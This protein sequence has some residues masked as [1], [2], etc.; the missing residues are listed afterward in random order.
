MIE[1]LVV[2][3]R[4]IHWG[5]TFLVLGVVALLVPLLAVA[6]APDAAPRA[7]PVLL[8]MVAEHPEA[9]VGVIVQKTVKD[10]NVEERVIQLGGVVTKDLHIINAFAAE[11]PA[12][13]VPELARVAGVR[14]VSLDA[15]VV[16]AGASC[17][18]CIDT[19]NLLN[20][21]VRAIGAD[22]LWNEAPYLQGQG[23]T[24]AVVD[25]GIAQH[26]DLNA[27]TDRRSPSRIV[28]SAG[29]NSSTGN[30]KDKYGHGTH[31]AGII[32]GNGALSRSAYIGVAPKVNLVNVKVTDD[33]GAGNT[34]DVVAGLQ[35][36]YDHKNVYNIRVVNLS[37]NSSVAESYH[38]SP[39]D[40]A[41]E[42]LWFNRI[43][44]VVSAGNNAT[45]GILYPPANDP[46]VITVGAT[47][48]QGTADTG[49]DGLASYSAYGTTES[50]FAKPDLVAPGTNIISLL[51]SKSC[52]LYKAHPSH[53]VSGPLA[54]PDHYFRMS[55][56]SMA[57]AVT[58]GAAALLLQDEPT[59]NPDQV[60][61]R[62]MTT[63]RPF[64]P[65]AGAG[66]L[67]VYAAV[68]S[69]TTATANTGTAASQLLWTGPDPVNWGSVSWGSVSWGSVSWGS[70]SWGSVSWGSVSW[71]SDYWG[72]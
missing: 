6:A 23:V 60:K 18:S 56:T 55:G 9:R 31:V 3:S 28:A 20:A 70:V 47:D 49:D 34:S 51:A 2:R 72:N 29:F 63:A 32:G 42:I 46:F 35:W 7:Q 52:E 22:Q 44:V 58:A 27:T 17:S 16:Q 69:T 48:D 11:L 71:G 45:S 26:D 38:T 57:S 54:G 59:L 36:V 19:S 8:A 65:G 40:A 50:G 30:F 37:L 33:R 13:A 12:Q 41:L 61:Y 15:P 62:L 24:V 53:R 10:T 39:L 66:Y 5:R 64:G 1:K 68:H 14:W 4:A 43:V 21:Y 25:S 67:D